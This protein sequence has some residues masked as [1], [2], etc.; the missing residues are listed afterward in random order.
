MGGMNLV[1]NVFNVTHR[2]IKTLSHSGL[3]GTR[4]IVVLPL[5]MDHIV[6]GLRNLIET[7]S[8][9]DLDSSISTQ[10]K[11]TFI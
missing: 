3:R 1:F 9:F 10:S 5:I 7:Q 11:S 6:I 8:E 2:E 4:L